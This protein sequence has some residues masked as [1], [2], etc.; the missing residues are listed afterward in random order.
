[1][2]HQKEKEFIFGTLKVT[3]LFNTGKKYYDLIAG[4]GSCNQGHVH[5]KIL[6]EFINQASQLTCISRVFYNDQ[7]ALAEK[8]LK[9]L[10]GFDRS[11]FGHGGV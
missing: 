9:D 6:K 3:V 1:M 5:P 8:K 2:W 7:L 11:F 10:F 4:I